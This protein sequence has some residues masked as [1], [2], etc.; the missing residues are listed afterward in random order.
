MN[1]LTVDLKKPVIAFKTGSS[2]DLIKNNLNGLVF[3]NFDY[4]D[5]ANNIFYY[6]KNNKFINKKNVS[7]SDQE[8]SKFNL[9]FIKKQFIEKVFND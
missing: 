5:I 7:I 9:E 6:L 2:S 3:D 4:N 1:N 8:N